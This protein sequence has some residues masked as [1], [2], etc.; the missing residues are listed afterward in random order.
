MQQPMR[1]RNFRRAAMPSRATCGEKLVCTARVSRAA[2]DD[3]VV[4][5]ARA[6]LDARGRRRGGLRRAF[7]ERAPSRMVKQ[8]DFGRR[9][10]VE[11][12]SL[13]PFAHTENPLGRKFSRIFASPKIVRCSVTNQPRNFYFDRVSPVIPE[14]SL[15]KSSVAH[16]TVLGSN[17]VEPTDGV[18]IL[19]FPSQYNHLFNLGSDTLESPNL[20]KRL[21]GPMDKARVYGTRD[22][23]FDP[24][25][26][27]KLL[28]FFPHSKPK[29]S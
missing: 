14:I 1:T 24:W 2:R 13:R 5:N 9:A 12:R 23:R 25:H 22:S 26:S 27:Q 4:R 10:E 18:I 28:F 21:C 29:L 8:S 15:G 20:S 17:R 19:V 6:P 11:P 7:G 3:D 16:N